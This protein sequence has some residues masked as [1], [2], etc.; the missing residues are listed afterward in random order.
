MSLLTQ[1]QS[2]QNQGYNQSANYSGQIL[3]L[4]AQLFGMGAGG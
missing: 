3:Q 1:L 4:L 2:F